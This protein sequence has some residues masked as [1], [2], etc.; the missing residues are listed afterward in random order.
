MTDIFDY[1][2]F[3]HSKLNQKGASCFPLGLDNLNKPLPVFNETSYYM[4]G[5]ELCRRG[6]Q[7]MINQQEIP[8]RVIEHLMN[9]AQERQEELKK[10]IEFYEKTL[11]EHEKQKRIIQ[12]RIV[13]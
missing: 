8:Y 5:D 13:R 10:Q 11:E 2:N 3:D 6:Y 9:K 7:E 4:M 12:E 1:K